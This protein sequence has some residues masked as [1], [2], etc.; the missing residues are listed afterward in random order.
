M[1]TTITTSAPN[2]TVLSRAP[3]LTPMRVVPC[4]HP[5]AVDALA[6]LESIDDIEIHDTVKRDG[7]VYFVVDVYLKHCTSHIPTTQVAVWTS[8]KKPP[9]HHHD[10]SALGHAALPDYRLEKRFADF[11][12]LRYQVWSTAQK[13]DACECCVHCE[14][15]MDFI[16]HSMSQPRLVV[17]LAT[18]TKMR[19]KLLATF[20]NEFVRLVLRGKAQRQH[21]ISVL[22]TILKAN[23]T[24]F[25]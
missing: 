16:V 4:D 8:Q 10:M 25:K 3:G 20:C 11:A 14:E 5:H 7:D 13:K 2:P 24:S 21:H 19:K 6:F 22:T 18:S 1:A 17:K 23:V 15:L 9:Q 12:D